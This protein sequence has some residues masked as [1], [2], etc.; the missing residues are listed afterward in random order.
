MV[1]FIHGMIV[2]GYAL[3][4]LFF[5]KFWRHS[6]DALFVKFA[7]AF[8]LFALNE[9]AVAMITNPLGEKSWPYL[10]RLAGFVLIAVAILQKNARR[11]P[12]ARFLPPE[13][14]G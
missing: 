9:V 13:Q 1:A 8:W 11:R 4:G 3:A 6:G 5:L 2:M 12:R 14:G 7:A 10:L